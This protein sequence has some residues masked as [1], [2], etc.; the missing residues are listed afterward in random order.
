[1]IYYVNM[2]KDT[3]RKKVG[4]PLKFKSPK[5]LQ[6]KI[7]YFWKWC[8]ENSVFP[9]VTR[10][11]LQLDTTRE[12]LM[13]YESK[14]EYSDAIKK[15]KLR[16]EANVEEALFNKDA[17]VVG[18]IFNLKN[19]YGWVDKSERDVTSGGKPINVNVVDFSGGNNTASSVPAE[20]LSDP[21]F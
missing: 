13:D 10:L 18:V 15:A 6:E 20:K 7:E 1:M 5:E 14:D 21:S 2:S 19:N 8:E 4:R 9:T 16:I 17:P 3:D 11:A 12:T